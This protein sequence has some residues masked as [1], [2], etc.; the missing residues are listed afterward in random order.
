MSIAL[1]TEAWIDKKR[2]SDVTNISNMASTLQAVQ[3]YKLCK[4][5]KHHTFLQ[6]N[7]TRYYNENVDINLVRM[8]RF[9]KNLHQLVRLKSKES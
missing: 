4:Y 5:N 8:T 7:W 2:S 6:Y 9:W 1:T 3:Q